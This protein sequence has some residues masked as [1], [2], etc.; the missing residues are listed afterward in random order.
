MRNRTDTRYPYQ[1]FSLMNN[2]S[3]I[4]TSP[5]N[6]HSALTKISRWSN[7]IS[8]WSQHTASLDNLPGGK[9]LRTTVRF[10]SVQRTSVAL[11][12]L[13]QDQ[14]QKEYYN[15]RA[16]IL[17]NQ[18]RIAVRSVHR[19]HLKGEIILLHG[20]L[21]TCQKKTFG[22]RVRKPNRHQIFKDYYDQEINSKTIDLIS[23]YGVAYR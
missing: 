13:Y 11:E 17:R 21:E 1:S 19:T 10:V 18:R 20:E 23:V 5:T 2:L 12:G 22:S 8:R 3:Y 16:F 4:I 7:G 6:S 15:L 9:N 14:F